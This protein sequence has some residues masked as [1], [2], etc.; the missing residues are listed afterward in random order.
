[1]EELQAEIEKIVGYKTYSDKRKVDT[2][3]EMDANLYCNLG[4]ESSKA[5]R[6]LVNKK[7]LTLFRG[8]KK[9]DWQLGCA[10]LLSMGKLK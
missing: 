1:M 8:I 10:L 2:M 9:V 3:L 6:E 4:M 7:S 5:E